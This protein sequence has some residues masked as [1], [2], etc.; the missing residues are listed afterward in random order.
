MKKIAVIDMGSNTFH[1][2][3]AHINGDQRTMVCRRSS[4]VGL[5]RGGINNNIILPE[6]FERALQTM[7]DFKTEIARHE[8]EVVYAYGTSAMRNAVNGTDLA[9]RIYT[10][11]GIPVTIISG[12]EEA[13]LIFAGILAALPLDTPALVVDIGAGSVEFII[14]DKTGIVWKKSFEVG[15]Q[16]LFEEFHRHDPITADEVNA[17][18]DHLNGAL[19]P[20][21]QALA[22]YQPRVL[23]GS[24]GSFDTLSEIHCIRQGIAVDRDAP[25]TPLTHS[26]FQTISDEI[27]A[28]NRAGR[29]A[30]EGMIEMRVDMIVCACC[31]IRTVLGRHH[32]E[33]IRVSSWSLKEGALYTIAWHGLT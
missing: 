18:N 12:E 31:L 20:L 5:A 4:V 26:D 1:L 8:A 28:K 17:L 24:S 27:L 7:K 19:E 30:I 23:V 29:M 32:F 22:R 10:E 33:A 25:E 6:A 2:L 13:S 21:Y 9:S 14:G 3:V 15:A 16:R 11:T